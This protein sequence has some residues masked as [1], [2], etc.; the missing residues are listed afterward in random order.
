MDTLASANI[1]IEAGFVDSQ[2]QAVIAVMNDNLATKDDLENLRCDMLEMG[3]S[4]RRDTKRDMKDLGTSLRRDMKEMDTSL[5]NDMT[6]GFDTLRHEMK[7]MDTS[8][9]SDMKEMNTSIRSD[10]TNGFDT[11]AHDIKGVHVKID[12]QF[13]LLKWM[14]GIMGAVSIAIGLRLLFL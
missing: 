8:L 2:A 10:M 3:T 9:R 5:R 4:I 1:L 13:S 11:V 12:Y 14:V 7:E 6:K